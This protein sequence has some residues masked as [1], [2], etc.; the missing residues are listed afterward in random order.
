MQDPLVSIV[1]PSY[2]QGHFIRSTIESVLAQ[3]YTKLEYIIM[4]GGS[5]DETASVVKDYSSRLTWI[6]EKDRGQ[7][8][9]INKGFQ[10]AAGEFVSWLNSDDT[11]LPGAVQTAVTALAENPD[12]GAVYGEGFCIDKEG[13]VTGR[14]PYTE[15]LNLWKLVHLSDYV[16]QQTVF[17]RRSCLEE[18]GYLKEELH[19]TMDWD[20]LIRIGLRRPLQYVPEYL[21]CIREHQDSKSFRGAG[22]RVTEIRKMLHTH[23]GLRYPPGYI[24]YGLDTY[25]KIWCGWIEERAPSASAWGIPATK[26]C[27][28]I[29]NACGMW[30]DR[31]I[32]HSQG[33]YTDGWAGPTVK[34]MI[35]P[36][37][38]KAILLEGEVPHWLDFEH[39]MLDI[40]FN[41]ARTCTLRLEPG[42]F[43]HAVTVPDECKDRALHIQLR[44]Q[45]HFVPSQRGSSM[46]RRKL[47]F[48]LKKVGLSQVTPLA[49]P[50]RDDERVACLASEA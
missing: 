34:L 26:L 30:I 18:V 39:Q 19:Y 44:A 20:L 42:P 16:L 5:T 43:R 22:R 40:D 28:L 9:A 15:P 17:F 11:L 27:S 35:P 24:V 48:L 2:N 46:D 12:A 10:M 23:T 32:L 31:I 21:G 49:A 3:N 47:S 8:H 4:D 38:G 1:T 7:S 25:R 41:G 36:T 45:R 14:F 33:W 50:G 13:K 37:R 6:S 29:S